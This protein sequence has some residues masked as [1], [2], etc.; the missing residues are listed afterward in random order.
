VL[1]FFRAQ[2]FSA[3]GSA[4]LILAIGNVLLANR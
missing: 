4:P 2:F 1:D 3:E